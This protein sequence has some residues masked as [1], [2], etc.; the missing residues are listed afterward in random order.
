MFVTSYSVDI[1]FLA[2]SLL[3][4]G[5]SSNTYYQPKNVCLWMMFDHFYLA[6]SAYKLRHSHRS[7]MIRDG[8]TNKSDLLTS[9]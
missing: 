7:T 1:V 8:A 4:K 6:C 9:L 3:T 5:L 2:N